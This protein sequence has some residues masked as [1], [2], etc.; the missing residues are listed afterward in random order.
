MSPLDDL[1]RD[2]L[3]ERKPDVPADLWKKIAAKKAP[4]G[5]QLDRLFAEGLGERQAAVPAGMWARIV[6][7]RRGV[8]YRAYAAALLLLLLTVA[9][10]S[11]W[12]QR[13]ATPQG[14]ETPPLS[15][16]LAGGA[17]EQ[18]IIAGALPA[19]GTGTRSAGGGESI[20]PLS[21]EKEGKTSTGAARSKAAG[22][23]P[24]RP[25]EELDAPNRRLEVPSAAATIAA[26]PLL[27]LE[28]TERD[29]GIGPVRARD[30]DP[31]RASGRN[32]LSGEVLFGAA[33]ANQSFGSRGGE[34]QRL[35]DLREVSEFPEVSYQFTARLRY[36]LH[37]RL[38]LLTGLTYAELRNQIEYERTNATGKELVRSNNRIRMLEVP[39]LASLELP[40]RRLRLNLNAGP[41]VHLTTGVSG[42]Y[43][44][45]DSVVPLEL[46]ADGLYRRDPGLGWTASLTTTY[47]IGKQRTTQLLLEPFFKHY[48]R[49]FTGGDAALSERYWV[50]GLQLGL[51][52]PL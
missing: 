42:Q 39:L 4:A 16:E 47:L 2:G 32:R 6:A 12:Y 52:K 23:L 15:T 22:A 30:N 37:G 43:L 45:P 38:H 31:L 7:A 28:I 3:G 44:D 24:D 19:D 20:I 10:G 1:F 35:R 18:S 29:P 14:S 36:R 50:A 8:G 25:I 27:P 46:N 49:S 26:L 40:G 13:G 21:V 5:E 11:L 9:V 34:A 17:Q 48:P 33:Y 41:V 51:R